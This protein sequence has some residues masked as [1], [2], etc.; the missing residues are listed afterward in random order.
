MVISKKSKT[1]IY[2]LLIIISMVSNCKKDNPLKD[3]ELSIK[4]M[5]YTGN[6]LKIEGYYY[7]EYKDVQNYIDVYFLFRNGI[8]LY[9][10]TFKKSELSTKETEYQTAEW[11]SIVKKSKY[12]WGVFN[13]E[14][15]VIKFERWYPSDP[16]LKAYVRAGEI[17]NDTTFMITES[18]RMYDGKKTEVHSK[19]E[20]Y[21]FK[22]FSHKPDSTNNFVE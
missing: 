17:L 22:Q 3:D 2:L 19:N 16:P 18:Y 12:R 6:Q 4:K 11:Q 9:G 10:S 8:I 13:I 15:N 5:D 20:I 14:N 7:Y 1:M 21:H